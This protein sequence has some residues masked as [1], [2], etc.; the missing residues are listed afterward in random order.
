MTENFRVSLDGFLNLLYHHGIILKDGGTPMR[1]T[2][3]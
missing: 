3:C 2:I 1:K